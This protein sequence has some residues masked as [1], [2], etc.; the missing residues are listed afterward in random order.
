MNPLLVKRR[1]AA[2]VERGSAGMRVRIAVRISRE[3]SRYVSF[4]QNGDAWLTEVMITKQFA[5]RK[6]IIVEMYSKQSHTPYLV[7][8]PRL[9]RKR[10]QDRNGI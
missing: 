4:V 5:G 10:E 9:A 3:R 7:P 6:E 8:P 1:F 2:R